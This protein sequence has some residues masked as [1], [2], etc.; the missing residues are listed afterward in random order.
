MCRGVT[1]T[2]R[3]GT[4]LGETEVCSD[5]VMN[6]LRGYQC[7]SLGYLIVLFVVPLACLFTLMTVA[8][9]GGFKVLVSIPIAL[10]AFSVFFQR[11]IVI[12][13]SAAGVSEIFLFGRA[14]RITPW[15]DIQTLQG[16]RFRARLLRNGDG[17]VRTVA[18]FDPHWAARPVVTAIRERLNQI[19]EATV[20]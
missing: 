19:N 13:V 10:L 5:C 11:A 12:E 8:T 20:E 16:G 17:S 3:S 15:A 1:L 2:R 7:A 4:G 9:G 18:M 14:S 6:P